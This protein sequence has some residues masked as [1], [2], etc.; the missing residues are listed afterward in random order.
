MDNRPDTRPEIEPFFWSINDLKWPIKG[1]TKPD[2]ILFDP[3]YFQKKADDYDAKS[4]SGLAREEYLTFLERL[5]ALACQNAKQT[6]QMAFINADWPPARKA[7]ASESGIFKA[8]PPG[9]KCGAI[10]YW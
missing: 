10:P 1:K 3:P 9:R 6:T 4:I 8:P 2:L 5:F 7:Y